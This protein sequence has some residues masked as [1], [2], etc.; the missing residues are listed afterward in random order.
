MSTILEEICARKR[1]ELED[2]KQ[3]VAPR[4]LYAK[5]EHIMD[6]NVPNLSL[7][8]ALGNSATGIISE[9]K[10]KSPSKGWINQQA[11]PQQ[12]TPG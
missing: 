2:I 5:V 1:L 4:R 9:F 12:T 10:R 7:S 6:L 8:R 3:A 11:D